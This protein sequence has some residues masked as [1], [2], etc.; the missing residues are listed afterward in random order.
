MPADTHEQ[1][2]GIM[3]ISQV[4]TPPADDQ[5]FGHQGFSGRAAA[6]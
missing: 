4:F 3:S 1:R 5:R 6:V 2:I